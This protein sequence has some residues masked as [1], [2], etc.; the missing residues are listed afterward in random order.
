MNAVANDKL[1]RGGSVARSLALCAVLAA[2]AATL[3]AAGRANSGEEPMTAKIDAIFSTLGDANLAGVVVLVRK[4]GREV[5][6]R[7]YGLRDLR[8]RSRIDAATNFRLAS[9]TKQFTAM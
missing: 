8:T 4:D 9:C 3:L 7:G 2:V 5:F 1:R 6:A